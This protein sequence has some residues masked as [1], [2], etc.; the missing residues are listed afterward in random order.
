MAEMERVFGLLS[1]IGKN[2]VEKDRNDRKK[3]D[4]YKLKLGNKLN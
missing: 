4:S 1:K 3:K 2:K